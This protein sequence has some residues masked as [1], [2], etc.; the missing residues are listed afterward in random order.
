MIG[1]QSDIPQNVS[2]QDVVNLFE[3]FEKSQST[4]FWKRHKYI[5]IK[6]NHLAL[7]N[8]KKGEIPISTLTKIVGGALNSDIHEF[9]K[10]HIQKGFDLFQEDFKS[11]HQSLISSF[12]SSQKIDEQTEKDLEEARGILETNSAVAVKNNANWLLS[13][14]D[15]HGYA[16]A[17]EYEA[18]KGYDENL[19]F[20]LSL[21]NP[22]SEE[23]WCDVIR[24]AVNYGHLSTAKILFSR[25][26]MTE[27][28]LGQALVSASCLFSD[29]KRRSLVNEILAKGKIISKEKL[30]E[31]IADASNRGDEPL[32]RLLFSKT[33]EI[34]V[35][36]LSLAVLHAAYHKEESLISFLL[37]KGKI[38]K[39]DFDGAVVNAARANNENV[40]YFLLLKDKEISKKFLGQAVSN[41]AANGN[42]KLVSF[43]LSEGREISEG[44]LDLAVENAASCGNENII[45]F[46]L[47]PGKIITSNRLPWILRYAIKNESIFNYVLPEGHTINSQALP[48]ILMNNLEHDPPIKEDLL[49]K[50]LSHSEAPLLE[51]RNSLVIFASSQGYLHL[52]EQLLRG[53]GITENTKNSAI[54]QAHE[55]ERETIRDM[56][57]TATIVEDIPSNTTSSGFSVDLEELKKDP[58]K[59]LTHIC[60]KGIPNSIHLSNYT[61]VIDA[62]GVTKQFIS[63]LGEALIEILPFPK[64][65]KIPMI[66]N[67]D[68]GSS[69]KLIEDQK[70]FLSQMG[71]LMSEVDAKNQFRSD[72]VLTGCVFDPKFL[73][74]V[75]LSLEDER[76][77]V[78]L[79][80]IATLVA[81]LLPTYKAYF[82]L[83]SNHSE[84]N[85][86]K[87]IA[88]ENKLDPEFDPN[89]SME[90]C[91][92]KCTTFV[93]SFLTPAQEFYKGATENFKK[94]IKETDA[95]TLSIS[96]QG[97]EVTTER[98]LNA[99]NFTSTEPEFIKMV[100]WIKEKIRSSDKQWQKK[101]L[102]TIT[103]QTSMTLNL[104][105]TLTPTENVQFRFHTC[106]N[107]MD[108]PTRAENKAVFL[109]HLDGNL[110][111]L[112][113]NMA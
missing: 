30:G 11:S 91:L 64:D 46:L 16:K 1:N 58:R 48:F 9:E 13:Q 78:I 87:F 83:F 111:G 93:R 14:V 63:S 97:D 69:S 95:E 57:N 86:V 5:V 68:V 60:D 100:G 26:E 21:K 55:N 76:E 51:S 27:N 10:Y 38:T 108:V 107:T 41:A 77:E 15:Q 49:L 39:E 32:V 81:P 85:K 54:A 34:S 28:I 19:L 25:N 2:P 88:F 23:S 61:G 44:D 106:F 3:A 59:F 22:I 90:E 47:P 71:R 80:S 33:E 40:I 98:L 18:S 20:L 7:S 12:F 37:G 36:H 24:G 70:L 112:D 65:E 42:E 101:F 8:H 52:L 66:T 99:L 113:Y 17:L 104:R 43:L 4:G 62:G 75:K 53:G 84:K 56:L 92:E 102:R 29:E 72:P 45:R 94:K 35:D 79:K 103:S 31:A 110:E 89:S 73:E 109:E 67:E 50:L 74:I 96:I 82:D 6:N 105:I